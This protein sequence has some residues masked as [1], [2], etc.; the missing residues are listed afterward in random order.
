[1]ACIPACMERVGVCTARAC[2]FQARSVA[3]TEG[4][5][6]CRA[7]Q[8][9][10]TERSCARLTRARHAQTR[11]MDAEVRSIGAEMPS[12]RTGMRSMRAGRRSMH[13]GMRSV[14]ANARLP[15]GKARACAA[16]VRSW[17]AAERACARMGR[18]WHA[19]MHAC[20]PIA[21]GWHPSMRASTPAAH[22]IALASHVLHLPDAASAARRVRRCLPI[23]RFRAFP[24]PR[25]APPRAGP[26]RA[27]TPGAPAMSRDARFV[28]FFRRA[29]LLALALPACGGST[30][31]GQPGDG[32][33]GSDAAVAPDATPLP[34]TMCDWQA[35]PRTNCQWSLTFVGDPTACAGFTGSGTPSE[36]LAVCGVSNSGVAPTSCT[37]EPAQAN[38]ARGT[39][40]CF[41]T[42]GACQPNVPPGNGGRRPGYFASLGFG[43]PPP[44]RELG[45]HFARVAC[46]EAGSVEAF[47]WLRDE[48]VAHGAPRRLVRAAERAIRDEKRHV[49]Q[50]S[51]L[52]RRF[53]EE[54]IA[55]L[56]AP[57]RAVRPLLAVA[58]ENA[59][60]G[61]VRE[62]YSA[63]ECACQAQVAADAVVRATM[64]RIARDEMRHLALSW[65]VHAWA[66]GRLAAADRARVRA[67][68]REAIAALRAELASDPHA[69]LLAAGGLPRA[70]Q[71]QALVGAIEQKLAA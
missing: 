65:A 68:Q 10:R 58:I 22:S 12:M 56:P 46:M 16:I 25:A 27:V 33:A 34:Q 53:G 11:F 60:E 45:T 39:M 59:V 57:P 20:A 40:S 52:A 71:S 19:P 64:Q 6:A 41:V 50:T 14:N 1:M 61:C 70:H 15:R 21:R 35:G 13:T 24:A 2:A 63:L 30:V 17:N 43:A 18:S 38:A 67:A 9:T 8:A 3:C 69:S 55:P 51:A 62:T 44:G 7:G 5:C 23:S 26:D 31:P 54:P 49:R 4:V 29:V 48:L 47:R 37:A 32:G 28:T 66:M 42:T 36:C